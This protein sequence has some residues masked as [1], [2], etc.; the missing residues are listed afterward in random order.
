MGTE[1]D[2]NMTNRFALTKTEEEAI[3]K[4]WPVHPNSNG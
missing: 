2:K 3:T 4:T 1:V